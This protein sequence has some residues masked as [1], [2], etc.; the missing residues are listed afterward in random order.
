[1][2]D[3]MENTFSPFARLANL[4]PESE[5][6]AITTAVTKTYT[7]THTQ[8]DMETMFRVWNTYVSPGEPQDIGC[9]GCRANVVNKLRQVV[10]LWIDGN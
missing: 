7:H 6:G 4:I 9:R 5:R 10:T 3:C 8:S 2:C 1:M